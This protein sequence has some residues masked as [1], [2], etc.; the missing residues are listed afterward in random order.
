MLL[1]DVELKLCLDRADPQQALM[2]VDAEWA[3]IQDTKFDIK[4]CYAT[5]E[6]ISSPDLR[7]YFDSIDYAPIRYDY[8]DCEVF[9]HSVPQGDTIV[10][11]NNIRGGNVPSHMF[12]GFI[13]TSALNGR[14][15]QSSTRFS[16]HNVQYMNISLNG[17]SVNGYPLRTQHNIVTQPLQKFLSCTNRTCNLNSGKLL[18]PN[19]FEFNWLWSHCFEAEDAAAGWIGVDF[20]L[21]D[22]FNKSMSM[23]VWI[24][25]SAAL[26]I[27]KYHQIEKITY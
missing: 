6:Y 25:S 15:D 4:D 1:K 2:C 23:V 20:K 26:A 7:S 14:Y 11:F 16:P 21:K 13:E 22:A 27:D 17:N 12:I 8:E 10:R 5:T 9:V 19:E 24:I 3:A 18:T